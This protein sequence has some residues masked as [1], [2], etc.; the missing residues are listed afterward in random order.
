M[1]MLFRIF[2]YIILT[3]CV[4]YGIYFLV[5]E[6]RN[7]FCKLQIQEIYLEEERPTFRIH[8]KFSNGGE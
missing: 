7:Y 2:V 1:K 5:H 8:T 6:Y 3:P 4:L